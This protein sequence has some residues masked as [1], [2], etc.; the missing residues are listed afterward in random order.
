M[1]YILEHIPEEAQETNRFYNHPKEWP[2]EEYKQDS[3]EEADR[4]AQFLFSCKEVECLLGTDDERY[5]RQEQQLL[6][7]HVLSFCNSKEI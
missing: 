7:S 6:S 4:A 2:L 1:R 3:T 5:A